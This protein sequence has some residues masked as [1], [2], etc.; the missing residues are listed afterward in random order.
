MNITCLFTDLH[1]WLPWQTLTWKQGD[2]FLYLPCLHRFD[3]KNDWVTVRFH[4]KHLWN[5]NSAKHPLNHSS[6]REPLWFLQTRSLSRGQDREKSLSL[7]RECH[8][9]DI[10][11]VWGKGVWEICS[12]MAQLEWGRGTV[13]PSPSFWKRQY[14]NKKSISVGQHSQCLSWKVL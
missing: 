7:F 1:A 3:G 5:M 6:I 14:K 10:S 4:K 8:P 11:V 2:S 13:F 9:T 12:H